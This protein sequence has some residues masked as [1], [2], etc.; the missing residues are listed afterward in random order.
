[1]LTMDKIRQQAEYLAKD[2]RET[3][4]TIEA[5]YWFPDEQEVRLVELTPVV[6]LNE[7]DQLR[8]FYF[9]ASVED[10]LPSPSG[11]A[12]IRPEEWRRLRL[13]KG[14]SYEHA[15][16]IANGKGKVAK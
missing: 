1:M 11:V 13:P 16:L 10:D 7:D 15:V 5:V 2:N 8:P 6:P 4:P 9:P 14:W 12:M 3:E